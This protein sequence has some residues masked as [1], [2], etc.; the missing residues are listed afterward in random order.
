MSVLNYRAYP[1]AVEFHKDRSFVRGIMGPF[2]CL[3]GD[4]EIQTIEGVKAISDIDKP[5]YVLSYDCQKDQFVMALTGGSYLK[6]RDYL[7]RVVTSNGEFVSSG[8]HRVLCGDGEYQQVQSLAQ[9]QSVYQYSGD[10]PVRRVSSSQVELSVDVLHYQGKHASYLGDCAKLNRQYGQRLLEVLGN[11]PVHLPLSDDVQKYGH[12]A[13]HVLNDYKDGLEELEQSHT[14]PNQYG[15]P[16]S[17]DGCSHLPLH[18]SIFEEDHGASI[19][20]LPQMDSDQPSQQSACK[21]ESH[22]SKGELNQ[23]CSY[24]S[25]SISKDTI[26]KIE[27]LDILEEYWDLMVLDTNN[28]VTIDGTIHHNSGKSVA[29][30][31]EIFQ[32]A[33]EQIQS[34]DGIRRSKWIIA[35]NTQ[36]ELETTTIRT[37]L[38]WFPEHIFGKM[39]RKPPFTHKLKFN[40]VELEVIFLALD[41]PDDV[42]KLLSFEVTGV[43]FNEAR[44]INYEMVEGATGRVGRYPPIKQKPEEVAKEDWPTWSG[45]IMDTN[46]PD[47]EHWWYRSAQLDHWAYDEDGR[48]H[49][50]LARFEKVDAIP[51]KFRWRFYQQPSGLDPLAENIE[52]LPGGYDYYHRQIP[53]KTKEWINVYVH[54]NYGTIMKGLP[55]YAG[56]YNPDIHKA[57][58]DLEKRPTGTIYVGI[59]AS[60]RHPASVF[61]QRMGDGQLQC[62]HEFCVT[63]QE[64][65]GAENY[66]RLLKQEMSTYFPE[67]DFEIWG[68]PAGAWG[69]N[70]DERT[71]T[72]I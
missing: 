53:G 13:C 20:S 9:G 67:C 14:H 33:Q 39:S 66:A 21:S 58:F 49:Q 48:L 16:H 35:R 55:V 12:D 72:L 4:T 2:G 44:E 61:L 37:W 31:F 40:D 7:Y 27:R 22:H 8:H 29:C 19:S 47:E 34:T 26:L 15:A 54:G 63:G 68:D 32:K 52:H 57:K 60:G 51:D 65:M 17:I 6:G 24:D 46:P 42:K 28:Y 30:C 56:A 59:D 41:R 64:G 71:G 23:R 62:V 43:W 5:T 3:R 38:E 45:I 10:Q 18:P 69:Q 1:T 25:T 36:P 70:S 50:N 11:A